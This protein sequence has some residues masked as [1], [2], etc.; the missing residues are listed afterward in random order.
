MLDTSNAAGKLTCHLLAVIAEFERD[1]IAERTR[2][3][4]LHFQR[5]GR[6]IG[7]HRP[8]GWLVGDDGSLQT[9]PEEQRLVARTQELRSTGMGLRKVA[10]VLLE[11]GFVPRPGAEFHPEQVRRW[12]Q[13]AWRLQVAGDDLAD[14]PGG[15]RR[16]PRTGSSP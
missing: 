16:G 14:P 11:E 15:V 9:L 2:M 12:V 13:S 7:G 1:I 4:L 6:Y 5:K 8:T 10:R 3:A